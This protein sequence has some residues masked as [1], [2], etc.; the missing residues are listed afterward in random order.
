MTTT[1]VA[2]TDLNAEA[3][4]RI[5]DYT[6]PAG[7][8]KR[9]NR[10][11]AENTTTAD[12]YR[13][14]YADFQHAVQLS[15]DYDEIL[16]SALAVV[17]TARLY[18]AEQMISTELR[19]HVRFQTAMEINYGGDAT[20][21]AFKFLDEQLR[22]LMRT[23]REQEPALQGISNASH[24]LRGGGASQDAWQVIED[25]IERYRELRRVQRHIFVVLGDAG[26]RPYRIDVLNRSGQLRAAFDHESSYTARR[27]FWRTA[28]DEQGSAGF[29]DW[30]TTPP[31]PQFDRDGADVFPDDAAAYLRW[32]SA[33]DK[34]WIPDEATLLSVHETAET[35]LTSAAVKNRIK[36]KEKYYDDRDLTPTKGVKVSIL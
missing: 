11:S 32:I 15:D 27:R 29:N 19:E 17:D 34:A 8:N 18:T 4:G 23:V 31:R 13:R 25:Q 21:P 10:L 35:M 26:A 28:R 30:L 7:V 20:R 2:A 24:A 16:A 14:A 36:A 6:D 22:D 3:L 5:R 33:D 1:A 9:T 12:P